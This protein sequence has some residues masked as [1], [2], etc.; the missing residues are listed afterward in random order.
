MGIICPSDK[1]FWS[2]L[3]LRATAKLRNCT[4]VLEP[5]NTPDFLN[6][7]R[8]HHH[9]LTTRRRDPTPQ[10]P[11]RYGFPLRA[12]EKRHP[13]PRRAENL[14]IRHSRPKWQVALPQLPPAPPHTDQAP[15][16]ATQ[17]IANVVKSSFG[18]SGLD[19]MM[20]DEIG[21]GCP[22]PSRRGIGGLTW[23]RT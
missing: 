1:K 17:A 4:G 12:A 23:S 22:R 13:L 10:I 18:P 15:V 6:H 19:K 21:V 14:G 20:V 16:L 2:C 8:S 5:V 9:D 3:R 11:L 7:P